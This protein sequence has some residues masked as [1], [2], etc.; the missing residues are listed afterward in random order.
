[1]KGQ[2]TSCTTIAKV[3]GKSRSTIY[4]EIMRNANNWGLYYEKHAHTRMLRR[5]RAAKSRFIVIDNDQ[6]ESGASAAWRASD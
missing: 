1:M 4:R 2:R 6:G 5:R 3:L